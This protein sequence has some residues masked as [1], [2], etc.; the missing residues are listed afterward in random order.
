MGVGEGR[1]A[2]INRGIPRIHSLREGLVEYGLYSLF[3]VEKVGNRGFAPQRMDAWNTPVYCG[4]AA[5]RGQFRAGF[6][7]EPSPYSRLLRPA[8][9]GI[10]PTLP[11]CPSR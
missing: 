7:W 4:H 10:P 11:S 5:T 1:V 8:R 2:A 3:V 6:C 9:R